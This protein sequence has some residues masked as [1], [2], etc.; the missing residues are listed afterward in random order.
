MWI[1]NRQYFDNSDDFKKL[2]KLI[3]HLNSRTDLVYDWSLGRIISWKYGLWDEK[4][5]NVAFF[6]KT[7]HLWFDYF[8]ELAGFTVSENGN[9][10]FHLAVK[11][12][13]AFLYPEMLEWISDNR[14]C[15]DDKLSVSVS[16][17][18]VKKRLTLERIGY[19]DRGECEETYIYHTKEM[20]PQDIALPLNYRVETMNEYKEI[21]KHISLRYYAFN[22]KGTLTNALLF[23]YGYA[24]KSPIYD[25]SMD[26]VLVNE[27]NEPIAGCIGFIDYENRIMEIEVVCTAEKYRGK[28]YAR[29]VIMECMKR[30]IERGMEKICISGW[31]DKTKK[32]YSSF[33]AY[34]SVITHRYEK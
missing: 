6:E 20:V 12:E 29:K 14:L 2:C 9:N 22:P 28:G 17:N 13:Y 18:D 16:K 24:N 15:A 3:I 21:D 25:A 7:A 8:D 4:K 1:T 30:G 23:A 34:K 26:I 11:D 32:L 27:V 10:E 5:Q 19:T 33:G 31:N